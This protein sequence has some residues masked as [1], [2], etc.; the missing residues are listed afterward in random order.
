MRILVF[1]AFYRPLRGGYSESL[2][3]LLRRLAGAGHQITVLTC[4]INRAQ[5]WEV[6]DE[7][8]VIRIP[9]WNPLWLNQ[10]YP[11]PRP[12]PAIMVFRQLR[13]EKFDLVSTQTRFYPT[14]WLGF[15]FA[16]LNGLP[17]VHTERGARHTFSKNFL[18]RAGGWLIDHT[19]GWVVCRFSNE[20]MGVSQAAS[21]F[22]RHLG[23]KSPVTIYNGVDVDFWETR[24]RPHSEDEITFLGRLVEAKGAQDLLKAI[25]L[26]DLRINIIGDGP[27]RRKLEQLAE[28]LNLKEQVI[29]WGELNLEEIRLIFSRTTVFVNPSYSEG[30]PRSVL[31]AGAA[32]LPIAASDVGGTKEILIDENHGLLFPPGQIE[33]L[34]EKIKILLN[35]QS[36]R[37]RIGKNVKNHIRLNFNHQLCV[38]STEKLLLET[39]RF[40]GRK[41]S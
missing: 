6:I 14:T 5:S 40:A 11:L 32:G 24:H 15:L 21:R 12:L 18:L 41:F 1:A 35:D 23:A 16:K 39:I 2:H 34:A 4:N 25:A 19:L 10:S 30:L 26:M 22:V 3:E 31:E 37:Q 7:V 13:Q 9:C 28:E 20:V 8:T 38:E 33:L 29:F 27:Y 36:K 17:V